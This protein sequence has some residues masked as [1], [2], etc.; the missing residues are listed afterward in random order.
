MVHEFQ[1]E[2][3]MKFWKIEFIKKKKVSLSLFCELNYSRYNNGSSIDN[4]LLC[5]I[6]KSIIFSLFLPPFP[7]SLFKF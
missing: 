1:K 7:H 4:S 3:N 5:D 6:L 2:K